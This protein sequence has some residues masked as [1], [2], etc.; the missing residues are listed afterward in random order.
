MTVLC[1]MTKFERKIRESKVLSVLVRFTERVK[2]PGENKLSLYEILWF[3][4]RELRSNQIFV[5]CAAVTYNF[6]MAIPPT[7]LVL[8]SLVPYLRLKNAEATILDTLK[9][10]A[11]NENLYNT[12]SGVVTDFMNN[13]QTGVLSSGIFFTLFFSS[14]GMMGFI[15]SFERRHLTVYVP[16]TGWGR[17]WAAIKLTLLLLLVAISSIVVLVLQ[18]Q[19]LDAW[20]LKVF[21]SITLIKLLSLLVV[22]FIIFFGIT[23]IYRYGPSL[24]ERV[25]FV[26]PGAVTATFLSIVTSTVF[27]FLVNNFIHY[28][29]VYGSIGT[30][31]A[32]M[33]WIW[34][35]T[36]VILIGYDLNVSVLLLKKSRR[37]E[38]P[39]ARRKKH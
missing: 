11:K 16:R 23:I 30:L 18:S 32:F 13:Q 19:V 6:V 17:R 22:V 31:M 26:N 1:G 4:F 15:R 24:S 5:R 14:N 12:I 34:L 29:K 25:K 9:I 33:V 36:L 2:F 28:N 20:L 8:F 21:G 7:L 3:F 37:D 27:F 38:Q 39:K 10:V 35:N